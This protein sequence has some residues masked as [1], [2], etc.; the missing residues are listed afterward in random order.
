MSNPVA[1]VPVENIAELTARLEKLNRKAIKLG[2]P[3]ISLSTG[4]LISRQVGPDEFVNVVPVWVEGEAPKLNGWQFVATLEHDENGTLIRRIP[5]FTDEVDLTEYRTATPDNC[6]QCHARRRRNDTYIVARTEADRTAGAHLLYS[7]PPVETKQVGSSCLKDFT[8]HKSPE[9]VAH[10]MAELRDYIED[11]RG[12]MY[13]GG[14]IIPRYS[15]VS[16][17]HVAAAVVRTNGYV[18]RRTSEET[19]EQPTAETVRTA[20]HLSQKRLLDLKIEDSDVERSDKALAWVRSLTDEDLE[21][22]YLYNLFTVCK[23]DTLADRQFGFAASALVAYDRAEERRIQREAAA[24]VDEFVGEK[25]K[26][27]DFIF[28][29]QR[30]F[31]NDGDYGMSYRHIVRDDEGHAL[32]WSTGAVKLEPGVRYT[33]NFNVKDHVEHPKYGKQTAIFRPRKGQPVEA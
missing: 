6:D 5:T 23:G 21:N 26:R 32:I 20:W 17:M 16:F 30:V 24:P 22:D 14:H 10:F 29:V 25:G 9:Q 3:E 13:E 2:C 1:E 27:R 28:T 7:G 4:E 12:G 19:G 18:S 8:G 31:E 15:V 33:G 11:I